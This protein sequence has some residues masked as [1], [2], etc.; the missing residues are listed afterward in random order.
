MMEKYSWNFNEDA[1]LWDNDA[2]DTIE[3]CA[4]DATATAAEYG[5][6]YHKTVYVGENSPFVPYVDAEAILEAVEEQACEFAGEIGGDWY[7]CDSKKP[8]QLEEL[9]G[10]LT[11]VVN[12]WMK[13][14]GYYPEFY[15][16]ENVKAYPLKLEVPQ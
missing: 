3:A 14:Y 1:E 9:S 4:E 15:A 11:A 8:E 2:H 10:A 6:D 7:A 13:K 12:E 16:V 5:K